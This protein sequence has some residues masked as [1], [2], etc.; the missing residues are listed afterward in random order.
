[1]NAYLF[2]GWTTRFLRGKEVDSC[3]SLIIYG[4]EEEA[5][6]RAFEN[7]L[8]GANDTEEPIP[9]KIKKI[10]GAPMLDCLLTETDFAT[11]DWDQIS[12]EALQTLGT[13]EDFESDLRQGFWVDCDQCVKPGRLSVSIA[14]L[15][16]ELPEEIRS[17]LNWS[18]EKNYFFLVTALSP[19][20][21][22]PE[23]AQEPGYEEVIRADDRPEDAEVA[24]LTIA[25]EL[26]GRGAAFPELAPKELAVL[27]RARNSVVAT[28]LWRRYAA[29]TPLAANAV[30]VDAWCGAMPITGVRE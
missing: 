9:T 4:G 12:E 22:N 18:A 14:L 3:D 23:F 1:M 7:L 29:S 19:P 16:Q 25:R 20:A 2:T 24:G 8:L 21:P 11:L 30:R 15:E 28:W 6:W 26:A 13:S 10:V 27:V 5:S 17:G